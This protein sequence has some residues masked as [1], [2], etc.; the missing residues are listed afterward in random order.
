[1]G[2]ELEPLVARFE[3]SL[4]KLRNLENNLTYHKYW[5]KAVVQYAAYF[6]KKNRLVALAREMNTLITNSGSQ[7]QIAEL[8]QQLLQRTAQ[9]KPTKGLQ[10][11]NHENGEMVLPVSVC[12]DIENSKFLRTFQ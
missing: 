1:M 4:K 7:E 5:Q 12:T 2:T 6:R 8:R 11:L 3:Q 10:I 9:F